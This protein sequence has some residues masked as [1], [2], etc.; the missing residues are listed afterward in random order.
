MLLR[1]F[2]AKIAKADGLRAPAG[3]VFDPAEWWLEEYGRVMPGT[4]PLPARRYVVTANREVT[5]VLTVHPDGRWELAEGTLAD[6]TH[7][8]CRAA[9]YTPAAGA[10]AIA[11]STCTPASADQARFRVPPGAEMPPIDGCVKQ[12]YRVLFVLGYST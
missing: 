7:L 4:Q 12:D 1:D 3:W 8:P 2:D 9:R 6:V 11:T 5:T 10:G